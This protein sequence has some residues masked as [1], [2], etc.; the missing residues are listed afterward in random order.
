M[1]I[2]KYNDFISTDK[3]T[4]DFIDGKITEEVFKNY[5]NSEV[6][7]E[8]IAANFIQ[9]KIT[10]VLNTFLV[11][12]Y[13]VGFSII[14]KFK[15]FFEWL[16]KTVD[17]FREK[18]PVLFKIILITIVTIIIL[19]V[20]AASAKAQS[21]GNPIP[22]EQINVA[23][24]WLDYLKKGHTD[25]D[26]LQIDKAIAH[27]VDIRDGH[28]EIQNL[29][30]DAIKI[31]DAALNTASQIMTDAKDKLSHNDESGAKMCYDLLTKGMDYIQ[32]IYTKTP[33]KET[34]RLGMN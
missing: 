22:K 24:G 12:A 11:K 1:R 7:N 19:I 13:Q 18:H 23:I 8:S 29:G 16:I 20:S 14:T 32:A 15:S 21:T 28:Q 10:K 31:S 17:K 33:D 25:L 30:A 2:Y 5:I 4:V 27:L 26:M 34:I 3:K 9:D 6:L